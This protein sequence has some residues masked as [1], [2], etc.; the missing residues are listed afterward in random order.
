MC[1]HAGEFISVGDTLK[2]LAFRTDSNSFMQKVRYITNYQKI[3]KDSTDKPI[4]ILPLMTEKN[5]LLQI[6]TVLFKQVLE[7]LPKS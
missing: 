5:M 4:L 7:I 3:I 1:K 2:S 6:D